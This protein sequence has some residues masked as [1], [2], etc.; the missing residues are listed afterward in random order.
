M[1]RRLEPMDR[2]KELGDASVPFP[3]DV[4]AMLYSA[5]APSLERKLHNA[6]ENKSV[7]KINPRKEFFAVSIND[8]KSVIESDTDIADDNAHW[9]MTAKAEEYR[10]SL[11]IG[12]VQK[13]VSLDKL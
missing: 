13:S 11:N 5:D 1:T 9:T 2:I 3:F 10:Q 8:I 4:H 7:N 6:F 12:S